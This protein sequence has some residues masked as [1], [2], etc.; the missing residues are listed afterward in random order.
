MYIRNKSLKWTF[1]I[2]CPME[3]EVNV[4]EMKT[5]NAYGKR[6]LKN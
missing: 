5:E 1:K 3:R 6:K 4:L 2:V